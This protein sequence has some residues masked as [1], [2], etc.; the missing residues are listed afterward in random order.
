M[1]EYLNEN[2]LFA[3]VAMYVQETSALVLVVEGD[4]DHLVLKHHCSSDLR[5]I[6][7]VGGR[8]QVL[9]AATLASRRNLNGVRFLVDRDYDDY[10]F[11][12]NE[13]EQNVCVSRGHDL[14]MDLLSGNPALL[15]R[16]I[17]VHSASVR[18]RPKESHL[19]VPDPTSIEQE[20]LELASRLAAVRIVNVR[21]NLSLDFKRFSF[22]A[23]NVRDFDTRVIAA[24]IMERSGYGPEQTAEV[25]QDSAQVFEEIQ[26]RHDA[27]VGDH[28]L[29]SALA[30]VLRRYEVLVRDD[31][32][33]RSFII[34]VDCAALIA[35]DW[36]REIQR[37]CARNNRKGFTCREGTLAA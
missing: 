7:G 4:D 21:R 35:A 34:G 27:T 6:A 17:D 15:R 3:T 12:D 2:T 5:L 32:L 36:F 37:W 31:V 33:H 10:T 24:M 28:D 19:P 1:R 13:Y 29:F 9:R 26:G 23:L 22:G 11:S 14:F 16:V 30:R 25:V 8:E 20:A 18:R